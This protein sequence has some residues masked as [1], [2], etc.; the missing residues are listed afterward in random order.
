M[1][2]LFLI[3]LEGNFYSCKHCQTHFA[4]EDDIISKSFQCRHGKAFLFDKVVNV[5][6]G[7][8]EER[9]M[10]TGLHTVVDIFCVVCG[11]IVGWRYEAAHEKTQ[12]YKEG[13]FILERF[14]VL[15]PDGSLYLAAQAA[16]S[17]ADD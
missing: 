5:T 17:D 15:G 2:R 14:K 3:N 1:G 11:S 8:K 7:E 10:I 9:M 16:G 13:K 6:V 4:L 12:K